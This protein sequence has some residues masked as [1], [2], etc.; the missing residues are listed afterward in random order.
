MR[1]G[2]RGVRVKRPRIEFA[3]C[4]WLPNKSCIAPQQTRITFR[5]RME[6]DWARWLEFQVENGDI[7]GWLYEPCVF[8]F[9]TLTAPRYRPDFLVITPSGR[10]Y[11]QEVKGLETSRDRTLQRRMAKYHPSVTI[12]QVN[13]RRFVDVMA[14]AVPAGLLRGKEVER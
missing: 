11:F 12:E 8:H 4:R 13:R 6:A 10:C 5:S 3:G 1:Y 2:P 14:T 9:P 7:A